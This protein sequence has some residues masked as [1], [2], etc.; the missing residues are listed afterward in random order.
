MPCDNLKN[1]IFIQLSFIG[2]SD[3]NSFCGVN[4][5]IS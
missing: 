5:I 1:E 2:Y 3:S 4:I